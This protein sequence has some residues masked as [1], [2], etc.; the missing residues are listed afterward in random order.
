VKNTFVFRFLLTTLNKILCFRNL[1]RVFRTL[2]LGKYIFMI[3]WLQYFAN[4]RYATNRK[5]PCLQ[6]VLQNACN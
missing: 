3:K 2:D 6:H 4:F 1:V 5:T